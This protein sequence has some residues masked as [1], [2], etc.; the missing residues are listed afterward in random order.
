MFLTVGLL[1][2]SISAWADQVLRQAQVTEVSGKVEWLKSGTQDWQA[3]SLNQQLSGGDK[4]RTAEA[5]SAVLTLDEG[6]KIDLFAGSEFGVQALIKDS[7]TEQLQTALAIMKGK[8]KAQVTPLKN[9]SSFEVETPVMVA[10]VR[11]TTFTI[12]INPDGSVSV[13]G[14]DGT[15]ELIRKGQNKFKVKLGKNKE[16]R[17]EV[18]LKTG[19]VRITA[20]KGD[21]D[22]TGPD[23]KVINL[24][25]GETVVLRGGAATF[26]PV[27]A[28]NQP[29]AGDSLGEPILGDTSDSSSS[30]PA[31]SLSEEPSGS[32][33]E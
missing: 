4:I 7:K 30:S 17:V 23:D 32:F 28:L 16:L 12:T 15:V 25:E 33:P 24:K 2:G 3:V 21:F 13:E 19:D 18:D 5:S 10:A 8:M 22:I 20:T 27:S 6:S 9:G 26:I 29:P 11:G 31:E 1:A 14:A